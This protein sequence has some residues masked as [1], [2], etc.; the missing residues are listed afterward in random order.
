VITGTGISYVRND[1]VNVI[2]LSSLGF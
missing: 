2:A 1:G